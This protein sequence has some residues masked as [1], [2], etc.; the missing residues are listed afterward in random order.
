MARMDATVALVTGSTRGIGRAVAELFASEGARVAVHGTRESDAAAVAATIPRAVGFGADMGDRE[1]VASMVQ[2]VTEALGPI[3]V[4]INNAGI[5][6]RSAIT[7]VTDEEWDRVIAV[8]LTGPLAAIRA[9]VP[10]MKRGSGGSIVNMISAAATDGFAG[11]SSYGA[12]KG[13]LL[14]LTNTLAVELA[15]FNIRVNAVS[16]SALTE[17]NRQLPPELLKTLVDRGMA[18]VESVADA[19]MFLASDMSRD[20]TGQVLEVTGGL[21]H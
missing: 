9:V 3:D 7:R 19:V 13:G 4:L 15:M 21:A 18:S 6:A 14:G 11:F 5:S 12:S 1:A 10:G 20:L 8:N 16:P 2:R 17:M